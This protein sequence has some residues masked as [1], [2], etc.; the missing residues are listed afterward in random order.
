MCL[1]LIAHDCVPGYRLVVA[2]NRDEFHG[3]P[4][5]PAGHWPGHTGLIAGRDLEG[6]GTWLGVTRYGG[7]ATVTNVRAGHAVPRGRRSRGL[8]VTDFLTGDASAAAFADALSAQAQAYDGFNLLAHDGR[9]LYWYS[10][11]GQPSA[12]QRVEPGVHTLSNALLDTSW[13]KTERLRTAFAGVV[14]GVRG[15]LVDALLDV[16]RDRRHAGDDDLPDT[17]VARDLER[18]LSPIFIESPS[19]G[20]RCSTIVTIDTAGRLCFHERRFDDG[21]AVTG[22][23]R[24][25][26]ELAGDGA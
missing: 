25:E 8:I 5:T 21:G 22:D 10:N 12:P 23:T 2:A 18:M 19:Y 16:L 1:L 6:G 15:T 7:F 20:T 3:R 9:E 24:Y 17:G 13:P 11:A 4:A 26:F 14:A